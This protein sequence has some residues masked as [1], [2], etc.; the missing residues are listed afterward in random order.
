[1]A[2]LLALSPIAL[3]IALMTG[4]G[5]SAARASSAA[6]ALAAIIAVAAFGYGSTAGELAGPLLEAAFT[7]GLIVWIVFPALALYEVQT[8]SG[9]AAQLGAWLAALSD[10]PEILALVLAWFFAL[11][12]EGAAGFGTPIALVAPM[13]VALG[14]APERALVMAL[15]GHAAGVSFGAVGIAMVPLIAASDAAPSML[16]GL[17]MALHSLL[18]W[19]LAALVY[20]MALPQPN[21]A[22]WFPAGLAAA[23]FLVPALALAVLAGPELP[24]LG[25]AGLGMAGFVAY[26]RW[27][28]GAAGPH[29]PSAPLMRRQLLDA[30]FPY[31][32]L[33]A[34][35]LVTRTAAPLKAVLLNVTLEWRFAEEFGG[36][37]QPLYHPGTMLLAALA[38]TALVQREKARV[39]APAVAAAAQRLPMVALALF[40]A[41]LLA[42]IM[43]H[44]SMIGA[45]GQGASA[46]LGAGWPLAAPIVGALGSF[47]TGSATASNILFA[48]LQVAASRGAGLDPVIALAGQ[49]FGA[50]IGNILAPQNIV[51]GAA[52]IG[53]V[54]RE[55]A[56]LRQTLPVC[57]IYAGL[58]GLLLLGFSRWL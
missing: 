47:V 46:L 39:L 54:G 5:W 36:V 40:A 27:R 8:R 7:A 28:G 34:L 22:A 18:G 16:A 30:V 29:R 33:L 58:G 1:M 41:L 50:A 42:R 21:Q 52:T 32:L 44:S 14:F 38:I 26:L 2:F 4:L 53:L 56:V 3:L 10:R 12:L 19:G 20:R 37:M 13:L 57:L 43:V 17:I 9:A 11:L 24:T 35:I 31:A 6:A 15:I 25:G 23:L 51:A 45:L 55:G 49:G 48:E